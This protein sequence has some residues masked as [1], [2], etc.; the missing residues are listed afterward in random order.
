[1]IK[2]ALALALLVAA[3][4]AAHAAETLQD[5]FQAMDTNRD[6]RVDAEE[7]A[8]AANAMFKQ[9][10]ADLDG[11]ITEDE[12]RVARKAMEQPASDEQVRKA[13]AA[14]DKNGDGKVDANEQLAMAIAM[15]QRTDA[16]QDGYVTLEEMQQATGPGGN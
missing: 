1:M 11:S 6:G 14:M 8:A 9:L 4:V 5:R 3:P 16:N 7:N 2:P 15:F 13:I 10:D 12:M